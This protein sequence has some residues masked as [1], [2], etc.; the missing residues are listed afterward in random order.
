MNY[1]K[2]VLLGLSIVSA[3]AWAGCLDAPRLL[4]VNTAGAEFNSAV[5]PGAINKNYI[6][7]T[8]PEL[9]FIKEQGATVIRLPIRWERIQRSLKSPLDVEEVQRIQQTI[10]SASAN[11]LCVMIDIHNY[12][13]YFGK[14]LMSDPSLQD[15]F[16]DLWLRIA[17]EFTNPD[18]VIFD[19]MNEPSHI[20][21]AD[22]ATLAKRTLAELRRANAKNVVMVS[23]G[24]W[25]GVHDWFS[26]QNGVSNAIAFADI[27]DPLNRVVLQAHQYVDSDYSGRGS[28]CRPPEQFD[29]M[30][31]R[32][33]AW[34]TTNNQRLFLGEFATPPTGNCLLTLERILQLTDNSNWRG[35]SYWATGRWWPTTY[36]F[37][38][39]TTSVGI[40]PQWGTLKKY[41]RASGSEQKSLSPPSPPNLKR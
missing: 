20:Q 33:N 15:G 13:N 23:G 16:V 14:D 34:A 2:L 7:P 36:P 22:W 11:G 37:V 27:K 25:S 30:F 31:Q 9:I 28:D 35:W 3:Q 41:F 17:R 21:V 38:L 19:L 39:T 5:L 8:L 12:G 1:L 10:Q 6:Y 32:I 26:P 4:G 18:A 29:A 40:S 24:K